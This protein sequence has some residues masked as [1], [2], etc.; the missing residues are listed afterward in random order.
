VLEFD[1]K[2]F[3]KR[4]QTRRAPMSFRVCR[5]AREYKLRCTLAA[6]TTNIYGEIYMAWR[7]EHKGTRSEL[8]AALDAERRSLAEFRWRATWERIRSFWPFYAAFELI[9]PGSDVPLDRVPESTWLAAKNLCGKFE[10][11]FDRFKDQ[12]HVSTQ[13]EAEM[14]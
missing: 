14:V 11:D 12:L 13:L 4:L 5:F 2:M 6:S 8:V 7:K 3:V 9:D 10:I 1:Y